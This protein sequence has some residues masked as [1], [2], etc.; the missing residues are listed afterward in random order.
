MALARSGVP[1]AEDLWVS[2]SQQAAEPDPESELRAKFRSFGPV[3]PITVGTLLGLAAQHGADFSDLR[4]QAA[5]ASS[6][7]IS[8]RRIRATPL[9]AADLV[10]IPTRKFYYGR[11]YVP[12]F[13]S[14]TVAPG[15]VGKSSLSLVEAIAMVTGRDLLGVRPRKRLRVWVW[16]GEDP[17]DELRRRI[18][19]ICLHYKIDPDELDGWLHQNTVPHHPLIGV[20][21]G[22]RQGEGGG[23]ER[24]S[25]ELDLEA[26]CPGPTDLSEFGFEC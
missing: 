23:A 1:E 14:V 18:S 6:A 16:N 25:F 3:G 11:H 20:W 17:V 5:P 21:G 8:R 15:G 24:D 10:N 4:A 26:L 19:A 7:T 9:R 2:F 12:T 22:V 13:V